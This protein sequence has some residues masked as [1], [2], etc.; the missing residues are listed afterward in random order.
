MRTSFRYNLPLFALLIIGTGLAIAAD[1]GDDHAFSYVGYLED[2]GAPVNTPRAMQFRLFKGESGGT[3][4]QTLSYTSV[5]VDSG[6]FSVMLSDISDTCVDTGRLFVEVSVADANETDYVAIGGRTRITS[7]PFAAAPS[8]GGFVVGNNDVVFTDPENGGAKMVLT[9]QDS[10]YPSSGL[11]LR[12][13]SNPANGE[14]L[15]QVLSSGGGIRLRV[16]HNGE[17]YT[18]GDIAATGDLSLSLI[19]I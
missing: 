3:D 14:A 13:L 19:H 17:L 16:E 18:D 10:A 1:T 5:D 7:L 6:T 2:D 11:T 15:F 12:T 8:S 4:C 9:G